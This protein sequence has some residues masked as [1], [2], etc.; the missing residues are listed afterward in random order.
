M[1]AVAAGMKC[2]LHEFD[3]DK[4]NLQE[5]E[6]ILNMKIRGFERVNSSLENIVMPKR[7][8]AKSAG[9]DFYLPCDVFIH[10]K[11][12]V[13]IK[14]GVKAYMRDDE[15]LKLYIRSSLAVKKGLELVNNVGIIDA[16]YY[17]NPDN[18][19]EI[20]AKI[21]NHSDDNVA[22]QVGDRFMQG[23][24]QKYLT[25]DN[26]DSKNKRVGGIGSTDV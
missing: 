23:V 9:Y 19:G 11:S 15:V 24:F 4:I 20:I 22:L 17:N 10:S 26:D 21:Y 1:F 25:V 2:G 7:A 13:T 8:T 14:T 6:R 18:E 12:C 16:D 3:F 5:E